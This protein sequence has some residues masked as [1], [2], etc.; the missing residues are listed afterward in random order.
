MA[1]LI[2]NL[3]IGLIFIVAGFIMIIIPNRVYSLILIA[4]IFASLWHGGLM[5]VHFVRKRKIM[6]GF[7][8]FS[9]FIFAFFLCSHQYFPEWVIR[10]GL[11]A[12]SIFYGLCC[13]IQWLIY[14]WNSNKGKLFT[15]INAIAFLSVGLYLLFYSQ[16]DSEWIM[17]FMG[18]YVLLLGFRYSCEMMFSLNPL[19]DHSWKRRYRLSLPTILCAFIPDWTFKILKKYDLKSE[20]ELESQIKTNLR[21]MVHVG[22]KGFQKVGHITIVFDNMVYSYGNYD[23]ESHRLNGTV[24]KGIFFLAPYD[25]YLPM[26]LS[27]EKNTIFEY[28]IQ[29]SLNQEKQLRDVLHHQMD[30]ATAW[31]APIQREPKSNLKMELEQDYANRLAYYSHASF[32]QIEKGRFKTYWALGANCALFIDSIL[33]VVGQ[34]VLNLRN[35]VSPGLYLDWLQKEYIK[36]NS[37]I[38]SRT[39]HSLIL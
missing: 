11:G 30:Q 5:T 27:K 33:S 36:K 24:G 26:I 20:D 38:V 25:L 31:Y 4:A 32:Y 10:V 2:L 39:I 28:G 9:S 37:P 15:F 34:D 17:M 3:C 8:A 29:L 22:P 16:F 35:V 21:L 13:F 12:Y 23:Q 19:M 14:V 18:I 6:D 7:L 1:E